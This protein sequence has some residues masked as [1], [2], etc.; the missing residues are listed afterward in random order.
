MIFFTLHH[1]VHKIAPSSWENVRKNALTF[2]IGTTFY[3]LLWGFVHLPHIFAHPIVMPLRNFYLYYILADIFSVGVLYKS[4][5]G[6]SIIE[7]IRD[8]NGQDWD[9]DEDKHQYKPRDHLKSRNQ[10]REEARKAFSEVASAEANDTCPSEEAT[11]EE[12][13]LDPPGAEG[14]PPMTLERAKKLQGD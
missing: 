8:P 5:Y 6:R 11:D 12:D 1:L 4:Y 13:S 10:R 14:K 2:I 7:E 9:F 3:Y